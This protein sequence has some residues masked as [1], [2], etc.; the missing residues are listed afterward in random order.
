VV[1]Y[2]HE[3]YFRERAARAAVNV[4]YCEMYGLCNIVRNVYLEEKIAFPHRRCR[5]DRLRWKH[6][7]ADRRFHTA[8]DGG[9]LARSGN[10]KYNRI[11]RYGSELSVYVI[12]IVY[13]RRQHL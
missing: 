11:K 10:S 13:A 9:I 1:C 7:H 4:Y 6:E 5:F 3:H 2:L 12:A 8:A